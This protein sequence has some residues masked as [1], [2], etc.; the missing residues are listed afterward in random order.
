MRKCCPGRWKLSTKINAR[1]LHDVANRWPGDSE[2]LKTMSIIDEHGRAQIRMAHLAVVGSFSVNGVA[3]L[4][5]ELLKRGMFKHFY[6]MWPEKFNNKTNGVTPRRWL[7]F[8]NPRL[9]GLI[10]EAIDGCWRSDLTELQRL[11]PFAG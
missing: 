5:T 6:E 10:E 1:F 8:C 2:R 7:A 9:A 4:H 11:K 3:A